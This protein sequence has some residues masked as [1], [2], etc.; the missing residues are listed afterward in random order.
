[1]EHSP[2]CTIP[3][4]YEKTLKIFLKHTKFKYVNHTKYLLHNNRTKLEIINRK[5][6]GKLKYVEIEQHTYKP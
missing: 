1:M 3:Y 5:I 4:V 2:R 6:T